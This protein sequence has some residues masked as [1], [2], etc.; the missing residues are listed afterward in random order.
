MVMLMADHQTSGGYPRI[1]NV[2]SA[3]LPIAA[4]LGPNDR[5]A[6]KVVDIGEAEEI[7]MKLEHEF[8]LFKVACR[9]KQHQN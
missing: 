8:T 7:R 6:F 5:V 3:D 9:L 1:G 4:Q 2:I